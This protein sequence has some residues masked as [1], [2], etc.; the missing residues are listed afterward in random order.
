MRPLT[1]N[2][3]LQYFYNSRKRN[4]FDR[5]I[6]YIVHDRDPFEQE[7]PLLLITLYGL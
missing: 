1:L 5:L 6:L 7:F 3:L 4:V 2:D